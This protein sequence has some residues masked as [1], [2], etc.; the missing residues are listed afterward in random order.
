MEALPEP[1]RGGSVEELRPFMNARTDDDDHDFILSVSWIL[2]ALRP[3]GPYPIDVHNGEQGS[4]KSTR[5][6]VM[7]R[8]IDPNKSDLRKEPKDSDDLLIAAKHG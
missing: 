2:A 6:R 5:G 7:R 1:Q 3:R 4:T 8:L